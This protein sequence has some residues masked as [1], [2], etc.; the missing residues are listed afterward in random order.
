LSHIIPSTDAQ[1]RN[2]L[3]LKKTL[4]LFVE[5]KEGENRSSEM[6]GSICREK[7]SMC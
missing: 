4:L 5:D 1:S 6:R 7:K 2:L 3:L